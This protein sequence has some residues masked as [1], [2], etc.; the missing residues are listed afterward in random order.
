MTG[1]SSSW[2]PEAGRQAIPAHELEQKKADLL[3]DLI[4]QQLLLSKGKELG[5]TGETELIKRL[6]E[7]PKAEPPGLDGRS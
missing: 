6:D 7:T 1:P 4:D 2:R 3:R 5:I